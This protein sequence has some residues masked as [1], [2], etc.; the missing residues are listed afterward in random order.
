MRALGLSTLLA[1]LAPAAG[2]AAGGPAG[3]GSVVAADGS[4][5]FA[6]VQEAINAAP[7]NA[8]PGAPWVIHVK[9][10]NYHEL[11]YI[12]R[13]KRFVRLVGADASRTTITFGLHASM[14]GGDGKPIGTF[15][16][17]TVWIDA[18]DF[19]AE[20]LTIANS[21]GRVG[22]A[23]AL[24]V[25]G[26]RV[27]F[28]RCNF[29]GW[30]DTIL[31]NRGRQYFRDC[32]I[33]GAVD[34]IFGAATAYFD[35]CDISCA[36]AGYITAASTPAAQPYGFIFSHCR[37]GGTSG[38]ASTYLGRPWRP[39]GCVA[40]L[41]CD[42]SSV[43]RTEGWDNW[44]KKSNE[45]TARFSEFGSKGDGA[46]P[47]GRVPWARPITAQKAAQCTAA[48]VLGGSDGWDPTQKD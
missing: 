33:T 10:G 13:E 48:A 1:L 46:D 2:A 39:Y 12:Q 15:R 38:S 14:P 6:T 30:Q 36:G 7:Q 29:V 11:V 27:A 40:F 34:F 41:D 5:D 21:A 22:Q 44:R 18:D 47:S 3:P 20:N 4:G 32:A 45:A 8:G 35:R 17:P 23:L 19:S 43:V 31:V 16:T 26:D 37:I 42:M 9:P 24:R 25:D 28:R